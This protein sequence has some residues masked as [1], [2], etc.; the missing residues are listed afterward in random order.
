MQQQAV[1]TD[2]SFQSVPEPVL[3]LLCCF[4]AMWPGGSEVK[5]SQRWF[6]TLP[7]LRRDFYEVPE[8]FNDTGLWTVE[9]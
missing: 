7:L 3:C 9:G 8:P 4:D 1:F 5:D 2:N 6:S